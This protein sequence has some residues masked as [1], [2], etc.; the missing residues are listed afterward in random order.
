MRRLAAGLAVVLVAAAAGAA[1]RAAGSGAGAA[2]VPGRPSAL[3]GATVSADTRFSPR[4]A[5]STRSG[6]VIATARGR[7]VTVYARPSVHAR[8]RTLRARTFHGRR[9]ALVFLV[10]RRRGIWLE[11]HLPTRPNR[12]TG[13]IRPHA[14]RLSQTAYRIEVRLRSHR[15]VLWRGR[16]A[17]L[18]TQIATG[19]AV[20]PTPTGR[21]YV[22]DLIRPPDPHGFFGPYALGLSAH[23]DVY[24]SFEGG[25]GQVGIHGTS[26]PGALGRDVS[27]G[28]IRVRNAAIVRLA[29]TVPLGTPVDV[30]RR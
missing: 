4:A 1:L 27:H 29:H 5:L 30:A 18:R 19:R 2:P 12:A 23:S 28:C 20:S 8:G 13:W 22:T 3:P 25:D 7:R 24:T 21:Y 15:L 6:H 16:R 10:K 11:V 17:V 26:R 9:L 14:V